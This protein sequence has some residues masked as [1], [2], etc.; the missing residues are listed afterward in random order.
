MV[1]HF[2]EDPTIRE[3]LP[4]AGTPGAPT[5]TMVWA[6]D[7]DHAPAYWFPRE[8]PRVTFWRGRLQSS[9]LGDALLTGVTAQRVHA[10]EW[11]WL[12]RIRCATVFRYAFDASDF[13]P[14]TRA[15]GHY[16]TPETVRPLYIEPLGDLLA[17]HAEAAIELRLLPTIWPLVDS[18]QDSG[19]GFSIIRAR[20]ALPRG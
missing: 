4:R 7:D 8:C 9:A 15:G 11:A 19:L 12:D 14:W 1:W 10:V 16:V 20:N 2:S 13:E 18:V 5:E 6:I 3:F 17:L